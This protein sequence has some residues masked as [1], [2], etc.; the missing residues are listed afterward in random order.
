MHL[1]EL[2]GNSFPFAGAIQMT[3]EDVVKFIDK[4]FTELLP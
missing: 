2:F 1:A 4:D 3:I